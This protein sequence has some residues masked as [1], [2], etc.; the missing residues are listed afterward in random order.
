M[1]HSSNG[2]HWRQMF[3][4]GRRSGPSAP[5]AHG[6]GNS[7][8]FGYDDGYDP[9]HE[10]GPARHVAPLSSEDVTDEAAMA[11]ALDA[12][13]YRPWIL[14]RGRSRPAFMLHLRRFEAKSRLWM[15]WQVAYAHLVAVEYTGEKMLS[16]DFGSRQFVI[17]GS[18]LDELARHLQTGSVLMMQE[19]T[20]SVWATRIGGPAIAAVKLV[21]AE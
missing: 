6:P 2:N 13:E 1:D 18:G 5:Q 12:A 17:E 16:L 21:M 9:A 10:A 14:Q 19:F 3:D 7:A 4:N 20:A 11:L 8:P 15:G